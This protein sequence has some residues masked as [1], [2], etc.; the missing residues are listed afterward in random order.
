[1]V[2][3]VMQSLKKNNYKLVHALINFEKN[4]MVFYNMYH[5]FFQL[6]ILRFELS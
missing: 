6:I 5:S 2:K 4:R 3:I 1:M